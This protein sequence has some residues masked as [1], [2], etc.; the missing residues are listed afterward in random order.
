MKILCTYARFDWEIPAPRKIIDFH[1]G[2]ATEAAG[3]RGSGCKAFNQMHPLAAIFRQHPKLTSY[4]GEEI[5]RYTAMTFKTFLSNWN[6]KTNFY[7]NTWLGKHN[8]GVPLFMSHLML[9]L[10]VMR[11]STV[12]N[13]REGPI[14]TRGE[15]GTIRRSKVIY[16]T[17]GFPFGG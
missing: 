9:D 13:W 14:L 11:V 4:R 10:P 17:K 7:G 2:G 6:E 8:N 12:Y 5:D 15:D 16:Q 3:F 1:L